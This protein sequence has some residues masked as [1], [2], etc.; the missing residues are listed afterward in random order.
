MLGGYGGSGVTDVLLVVGDV[1]LR[2]LLGLQLEL[3]GYDV[4]KVA[5]GLECAT[6]LEECETLPDVVLVDEVLP[7]ASGDRVA[8]RLT[9]EHGDDLSVMLLLTT[10][11]ADDTGA[12]SL[13]K[14][15]DPTELGS[16][17]ARHV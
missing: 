5:D 8:S 7:R 2:A 16:A 4:T 6:H 9:D 3:D 11:E 1:E 12:V 15:L 14:P 13:E 17:V 10:D